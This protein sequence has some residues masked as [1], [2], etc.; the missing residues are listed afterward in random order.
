M[1]VHALLRPSRAASTRSRPRH[2]MVRR[3]PRNNR[4][5]VTKV[6]R[7]RRAAGGGRTGPDNAKARTTEVVRALIGA[8]SGATRPRPSRVT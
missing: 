5:S 3:I 7:G 1:P 8:R 2:I 4:P 6:F